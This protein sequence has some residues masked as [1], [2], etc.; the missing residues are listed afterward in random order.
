MVLKQK[1]LLRTRWI[2]HLYVYTPHAPSP[3]HFVK[4]NS[5][6]DSL[7]GAIVT[8]FSLLENTLDAAEVDAVVVPVW[9]DPVLSESA[10]TVQAQND[11][12]ITRLIQENDFEA[13]AGE[14]NTVRHVAGIKAQRLVLL[15]MGK[16]DEYDEDGFIQAVKSLMKNTRYTNLAVD[17]LDWIPQGRDWHWALQEWVHAALTIKEP[18]PKEAGTAVNPRSV[19]FCVEHKEA[20]AQQSVQ[21]GRIVARAV[22]QAKRWANLPANICTPEFLAQEALQMQAIEH[23]SVRIFDRDAVKNLGMNAFLSVAQGSEVAPY[24]IHMRYDGADQNDAPIVLVGKGLTFD[25]GGICLKPGAGMTEMKYDMCGAASVMAAFEA[26]ARLRVNKNIVAIV[27]ACENMP[28]G[29]A[30]KPSDVLTTLS[31]KTV[32]VQ[33]TDAEGRLVLA[34][35]LTLAEREHPACIVDV[36]TLTGAVG[37]ALGDNHHGLFCNNP[38]L[39]DALQAAADTAHEDLWPLPMGGKYF[40]KLIKSNVADVANIGPKGTAGASVAATFLA[41]FVQDSTPWAHLDIAM[42]A[43]VSGREPLATGR[44][45]PML[46]AWLTQNEACRG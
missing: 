29:L 25:A 9:S 38:A 46:I 8:D 32:E 17:I 37:V 7:V 20:S 45:V 6:Y 42:T 16:F 4:M 30:Y 40:N 24:L 41:Q 22:N 15:G 11:G 39:Q 14:I 23:V 3:S 33:N 27:P 36:A 26:A 5:F 2:A 18:L 44:P 13:R 34:D 21:K 1:L 10:A 12:L 19:T 43:W 31:G 28:D 35:A